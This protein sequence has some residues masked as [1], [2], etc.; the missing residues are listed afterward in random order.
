MRALRIALVANAFLEMENAR[1]TRQTS[2]G[3][4]RGRMPAKKT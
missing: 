2:I 1:L 3:Y 4:T